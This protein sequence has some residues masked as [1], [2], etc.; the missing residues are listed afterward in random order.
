MQMAKKLV[1]VTDTGYVSNEV[2]TYLENA[3]YYIFESNHD[4]ETLMNTNRPMFLKQR[5][6]GDSV[7]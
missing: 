7:T 5:I 1:Y 2:K 4:I 3:D 6:L